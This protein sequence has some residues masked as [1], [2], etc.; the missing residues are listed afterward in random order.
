MTVL[1]HPN[2]IEQLYLSALTKLNLYLNSYSTGTREKRGGVRDE[3]GGEYMFRIVGKEVSV[4]DWV[5]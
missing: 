1:Y 5:I 2:S 3:E 4:V